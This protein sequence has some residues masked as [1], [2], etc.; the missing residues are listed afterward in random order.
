M[1]ITVTLEKQY[2]KTVMSLKAINIL[3]RSKTS[4]D[5]LNKSRFICTERRRYEYKTLDNR[6]YVYKPN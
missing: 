6:A 1:D 4:N 5:V 3:Y 2:Y